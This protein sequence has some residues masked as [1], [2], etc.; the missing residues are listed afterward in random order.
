MSTTMEAKLSAAGAIVATDPGTEKV[1]P[2]VACSYSHPALAGRTVVRVLPQGLQ[3]AEDL[4]LSTMGLEADSSATVG[5]S[6][7]IA[8]G[9]PA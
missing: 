6:R 7:R 2:Y 5:F 9:F 8:L 3:E 1:V 4:A